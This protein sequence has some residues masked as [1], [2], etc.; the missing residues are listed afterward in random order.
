MGDGGQPND[1]TTASGFVHIISMIRVAQIT[2]THTHIFVHR[3]DFERTTNTALVGGGL[4]NIPDGV[5]R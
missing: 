2:H 3:T 4:T 5:G 1:R